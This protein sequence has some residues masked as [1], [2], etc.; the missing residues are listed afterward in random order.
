MSGS[1]PV[2]P[3]HMPMIRHG[4]PLKRWR[5]VGAFGP[6]LMLCAAEV[7]VGPLAQRFFAVA[8]PGRPVVERTSLRRGLVEMEASRV[9]LRTPDLAAEIDLGE[10]TGVET[11]H[12]NGSRGYVWT[13]KQAGIPADVSIT[14]GG[15]SRRLALRGVVDDTAGYHARHTRWHW[16]AGVGRAQSG[17]AVAW[18]LVSGVNDAPRGSERALWVDGSAVEVAAVSFAADLSRIE[19]GGGGALRF[20]PWSERAARTNL[21]LLRSSYRQP[22]GTF[23]GDLPGGLRL[24]EGHGVIEWHDAHW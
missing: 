13:R 15:R 12:P 23:S 7:H 22:F 17:E 6:D 3:A 4:R 21:L 8:E 24:V 20:E 9:R 1:V 19:L 2:P 16:S 10:Q 5:Y 11:L 18:N 14:M